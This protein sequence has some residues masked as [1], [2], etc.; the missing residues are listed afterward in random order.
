MASTH[1]WTQ[2][3]MTTITFT[4]QSRGILHFDKALGAR[5][6]TS[7]THMRSTQAPAATPVSPRPQL[8]ISLLT[9]TPLKEL[10]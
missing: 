10:G 2:K 5:A 7:R 9:L 4:T 8:L 3:N 1:L 6:V